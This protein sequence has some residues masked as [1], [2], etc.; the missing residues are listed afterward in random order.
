MEAKA[1]LKMTRVTPRKAKLVLELI[2]RKNVQDA[3]VILENAEKRVAPIILKLLNSAI[4]NATQN[5][6]ML[7]ENL[8]IKTAVANEGPTI[9]RF[10]P[11]ARG[12]A[13]SIFKRTSHIEIVLSDEIRGGK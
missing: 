3:I 13:F 8:W 9:K 1:L 12:R 7:L 2:R 11:R 4:A 5:H 6:G 10:H